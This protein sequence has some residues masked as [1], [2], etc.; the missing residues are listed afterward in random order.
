MGIFRAKVMPGERA[1]I[2]VIYGNL[3]VIRITL[4]EEGWKFMV[5]HHT[6]IKFIK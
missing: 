6:W 4:E 3:Q 2:Q 1:E 5:A